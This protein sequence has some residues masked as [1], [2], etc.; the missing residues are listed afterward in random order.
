MKPIKLT[1]RVQS[2]TYPILIGCNLIKDLEKYFKKNSINFNR[3]LLIIDK[4]VPIKMITKIVKALKNK[5]IL[6]FYF[7]ANEKN[8][9]IKNLNKILEILLKKNF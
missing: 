9:N 4:N 6:K 7:N 1:V 8:K 2:A 5:N 3:C